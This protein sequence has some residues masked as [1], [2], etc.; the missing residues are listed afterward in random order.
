VTDRWIRAVDWISRRHV[1]V[2]LI[3]AALLAAATLF[4]F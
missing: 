1:S 2:F 4:G 3:A